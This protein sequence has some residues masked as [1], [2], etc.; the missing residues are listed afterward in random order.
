[1]VNAAGQNHPH[2]WSI[3]PMHGPLKFLAHATSLQGYPSIVYHLSRK[4][5]L[6]MFYAPG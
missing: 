1:M 3:Y 2:S 5:L 4:L 6:L